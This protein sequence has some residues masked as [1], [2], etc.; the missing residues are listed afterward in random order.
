MAPRTNFRWI[1]LS[2]SRHEPIRMDIGD[3][4]FG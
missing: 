2:F 3:Y 4:P 1:A